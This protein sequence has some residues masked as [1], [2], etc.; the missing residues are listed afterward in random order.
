MDG[1]LRVD[2]DRGVQNPQRLFQSESN[3]NLEVSNSLEHYSGRSPG[4]QPTS[5][6][7][8]SKVHLDANGASAGTREW[9]HRS[10]AL[11]P[12][13]N[14]LSQGKSRVGPETGLLE[15]GDLGANDLNDISPLDAPGYMRSSTNPPNAHHMSS[16]DAIGRRRSQS[17]GSGSRG[18]RIAALS[19]QLRTRLSYAASRIEKK[20]H[21]HLYQYQPP[22]RLQQRNSST[23]ILSAET[24]SQAGQP[25]SVGDI[26]DQRSAEIGTPDG[27]TVSAPDAPPTSNPYPFETHMQPSPEGLASGLYPQAQP[28]PF[29]YFARSPEQSAPP[30]LAAPADIGPGRINGQRRRSIPNIPGNS[31]R[32]APFPLYARRR[33]QQEL[34]I[35]SEV[36][37]VPETPPL[38]PSTHNNRIPYSGLSDNSQSSSME[39]DAIETLLFMSSPGT[40]GYHSSSQNSQRNQDIRNIDSSTSQ[41]VQWHGKPENDRRGSGHVS[42]ANLETQAG[43][44]IDFMLDQMNSDSDDEPDHTSSRPKASGAAGHSVQH[45]T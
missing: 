17:I 27:T 3:P 43:D 21:S 26:E 12:K 2:T 35:D 39:Q 36:V 13:G 22:A 31:S 9:S 34:L 40:S 8:D 28:D 7:V 14:P 25:L 1:S 32:Y 19:V 42:S 23:P 5:F 30:R 20:R 41:G 4:V 44:E 37:R 38:R 16:L 29:R 24:L 18:S 10:P 33:S 11:S 45:G 6:D 15:V